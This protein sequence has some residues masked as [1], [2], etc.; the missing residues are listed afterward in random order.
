MFPMGYL[1]VEYIGGPEIVYY[2]C[3]IHKENKTR[4][5]KDA[6]DNGEM[7]LVLLAEPTKTTINVVSPVFIAPYY[8]GIEWPLGTKHFSMI[9]S[10]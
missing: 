6:A 10:F 9:M 8:T 7:V 1:S 5:L 4:L 2:T 3:C